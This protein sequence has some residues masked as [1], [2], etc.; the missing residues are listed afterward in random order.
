MNKRIAVHV[1]GIVQGIGFR[2]FIYR[3][4]KRLDLS[5]YVRNN[6]TGVLIEIQGEKNNIDYFI[7]TLKNYPPPLAQLTAIKTRTVAVKNETGFKII[8]S[9]RF[10][11]RNTLIS[12]DIATC[13]DCNHE[14][15]HAGDRRYLYPFIN[16]TH[17]GP[18]FTIITDI[19]YDRPNTSM[20]EFI[21][22]P[23][24]QKEYD[25]PA[26][27][28][29]HAQ[30]NACPLCGPWL[31]FFD[32]NGKLMRGDPLMNAIGAI[33]N[34]YIVALKGVGGFHLAVD[35]Y[36]RNA[37][38]RLRRRK[39]RFEKPLALMVRDL[40]YAQEIVYLSDAEKI[41]IASPQRPIVLCRTKKDLSFAKEVSP[42]NNYLGI[43]LPYS[44][45][46]TL[47]FEKSAFRCLVMTS[48]NISEEPI[49]YQNKECFIRMKEIVDCFL[50]HNR[51]IYTRCDDSVIRLYKNRPFIIRR[52]RGYAPRPIILKKA[53][54]SVL[55]VGGQLK[56]SI[57]LTKDN[58][59]FVS[60]HIG[61]LENLETLSY[62]EH[63]IRYFQRLFEISPERIIYDLH[64]DYLSTKWAKENDAIP[65]FPLQHHYAHSLSVMAENGIEDEIIGI[66]LDGNGYG[67][68][69]QIW[70]GE[71]LICNVSN[72]QRY[73]YFSYIPMPGGEYA[74]K[75]TW[76]MACSYLFHY[77]PDAIKIAREL[78]PKQVKKMELIKNMIDKNINS[79]L[80]SSCGRLFDAVAAILGIREEISYEGQAAILLEAAAERYRGNSVADIGQFKLVEKGDTFIIDSK[81]IIQ[82]IVQFTFCG[83]PV[84]VLSYA[85]HQKL[86][87]MFITLAVKIRD[88]TKIN[89]VALSGGCFQNMILLSGVYEALVKKGFEVYTNSEVPVNDGGIS[90]GQ[91][92]WG[93]R[94]VD[95]LLS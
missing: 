43:M 64:P 7:K 1:Y 5:G 77:L 40:K 89:Q 69:G 59:A 52:S 67:S 48:A 10:D 50:F 39:H 78:F 70:G 80:T 44:P 28:R 34:G 90:L 36:N 6:S 57:C 11:Q 12:P 95:V 13:D 37:V 58:L 49:C 16:C 61:D 93:M 54:K 87:E 4:A 66:S 84:E 31:E 24:C 47:L 25:N 46:H 8:K 18:R 56:S 21:M 73:G 23:E 75:Q 38:A 2:P 63:T 15:V 92:Y 82:R 74:I 27:R 3:L 81:E 55:A 26:D 60:Q 32:R 86:I 17:C 41:Q 30:P 35:A 51:E 29:F 19:P 45:L 22:C 72:F 91:A 33:E 76:R 20:S 65:S 85:F 83:S 71:I 53:A 79:P 9:K 42:D 68:D 94:N 62:F 88:K 14:L